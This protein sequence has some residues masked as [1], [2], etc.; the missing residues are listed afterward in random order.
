MHFN[1]AISQMMV[2]INECYKQDSLPLEY[3]EGFVKML[4][5]IAPHVCEE[6]W[7][8]LG[9]EDSIS[10]AS[11]PTFDASKLIDEQ[12]EY[13]VQVNGKV[14]AHIQTERDADR[15]NVENIALANENVK[16]F[17]DGKNIRKVI[18]VPNKIV[19]IVAN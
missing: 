10:Y 15:Q 3:V 11:W 6:L 17:V 19:N 4:A 13:V 5:P 16:E 14:R 2:F 9:H 18:V 7:S 1:V 8:K 12:V